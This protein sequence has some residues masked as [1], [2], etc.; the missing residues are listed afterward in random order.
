MHVWGVHTGKCEEAKG[1][2]R[3]GRLISVSFP[4]TGS[5]SEPEARL[6]ASK[7]H[8]SSCLCAHKNEIMGTP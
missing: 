2:C 1:G 4:E 3:M 6:P 8:Q 5:L 7:F